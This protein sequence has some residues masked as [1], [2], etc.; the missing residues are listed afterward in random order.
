MAVV[1]GV[2]AGDVGWVLTRGDDA[3]V[4]GS[5]VA[6]DLGVVD[7][8]RGYPNRRTVAVLADVGRLNMGLILAGCVRAVV[9]ADAV[10]KDVH[11]IEICWD[12]TDGCVAVF[13][14]TA[15]RNMSRMLSGGAETVVTANTITYNATVVEYSRQ[16]GRCRMAIVA[17]IAGGN[18]V[19]RFAG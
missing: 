4:A 12:P 14:G 11:M 19:E 18:M 3:I 5:T 13:A 6:N 7:G 15:A 17:L 2:A 8:Y 16:P 1:A 10:T 9:A